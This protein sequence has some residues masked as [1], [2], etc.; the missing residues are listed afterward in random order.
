MLKVTLFMREHPD[1]EELLK[2]APYYL[3]ITHDGRYVC[4]TYD[5]VHSDFNEPIC[6]ECR[7][8]IVDAEND[9]EPVRMAFRKF[10]NIDEPFAAA[11]DWDTA[12]ASEK[13]DGSII[14]VW[15]HDGKWHV[16]TNNCIHAE[17]AVYDRKGNNFRTLFDVAAKN[18]GFSFDRLDKTRCYTFELVSPESRVVILYPETRLYHLLTRDI[19]TLEEI[20]EDI[21]VEKPTRYPLT[22]EASI[23]ATVEALGSEHEGVVVKDAFG[24]R[25]K[26]KTKTYLM[27]HHLRSNMS[28]PNAV[29]LVRMNDHAEFVSYFKEYKDCFDCIEETVHTIT[30]QSKALDETMSFLHAAYGNLYQTSKYKEGIL[31]RRFSQGMQKLDRNLF[32]RAM[33]AYDGGHPKHMANMT[34]SQYIRFTRK[35]WEKV[36]QAF[37]EFFDE[38]D[39]KNV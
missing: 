16:S 29:Q 12:T 22:S 38:E 6:Q 1:W 5:L 24:N 14:S 20:E 30:E 3:Q 39:I 35:Y 9:Y 32:V 19:R 7:G 26:I 17:N 34:A 25:V 33:D 8:L 21:G 28:L 15:Y 11:I 23:R 36:V 4:L 27:M 10:F 37:P 18:S 31:R 2:D 13:V